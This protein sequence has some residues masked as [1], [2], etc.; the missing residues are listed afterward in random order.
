[1]R[2]VQLLIVLLSLSCASFA[3]TR[4]QLVK[5]TADKDSQEYYDNHIKGHTEHPGDTTVTLAMTYAEGAAM[6]HGF[7]EELY[8]NLYVG[9]FMDAIA[10]RWAL[11][12]AG[13][14]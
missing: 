12:R 7:R 14:K 2:T 9:A 11:E 6:G 4:E 10:M 13:K 3:E 8:K 1:M 5:E